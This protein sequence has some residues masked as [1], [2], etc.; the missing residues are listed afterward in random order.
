MYPQADG[1]TMVNR[2]SVRKLGAVVG[3]DNRMLPAR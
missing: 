3:P 2:V 1:V